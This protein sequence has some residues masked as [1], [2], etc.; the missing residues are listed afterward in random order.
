MSYLKLIVLGGDDAGWINKGAEDL[1]YCVRQLDGFHLARSCK[2]GWKNGLDMYFA[3]RSG[4]VRKTLGKLEERSGKSAIKER[5][6][7][8]KCLDRGVDWRM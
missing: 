1:P 8:Y 2:R 4:K 6:H 7:V 3:I 5:E